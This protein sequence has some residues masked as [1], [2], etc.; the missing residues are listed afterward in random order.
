MLRRQ[1][2]EAQSNFEREVSRS[3]GCQ[4]ASFSCIVKP[5]A[6]V[7]HTSAGDRAQ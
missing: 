2:Q 3:V 1:L 5:F 7:L 6:Q 4:L